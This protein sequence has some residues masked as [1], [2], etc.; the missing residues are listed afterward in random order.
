M[1]NSKT[2]IAFSIFFFVLLG[3]GCTPKSVETLRTLEFQQKI[4]SRSEVGS[5][6]GSAFRVE[7]FDS[8]LAE[9]GTSSVA[10][11]VILFEPLNVEKLAEIFNQEKSPTIV[12]F[13]ANID[14]KKTPLQNELFIGTTPFSGSL[15]FEAV[16]NA[17]ADFW[18]SNI[19]DELDENIAKGNQFQI[20]SLEVKGSANEIRNWWQE[21]FDQIAEVKVDI[22]QFESIEQFY[23]SIQ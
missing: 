21:N 12:S 6:I 1:L 4:A 23:E 7:M 8:L 22:E 17:I 19:V 14:D 20:T 5:N 18:G 13:T 9:Q 15:S 2:V 10:A 11:Q 3:I 16:H